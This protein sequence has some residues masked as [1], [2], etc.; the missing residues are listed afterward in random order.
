MIFLEVD[1]D[2]DIISFDPLSPNKE[3]PSSNNQTSEPSVFPV[4]A[5]DENVDGFDLKDFDPLSTD[6]IQE[7]IRTEKMNAE[8]LRRSG[9]VVSTRV[10][11]RV[12]SGKSWIERTFSTP[13]SPNSEV[14]FLSFTS[15]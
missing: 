14:F 4:S 3:T 9:E 10:S 11:S 15:I 7:G 2:D 5:Q 13:M 6:E 1:A 12:L 8:Q